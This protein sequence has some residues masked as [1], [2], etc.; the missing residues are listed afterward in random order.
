MGTQQVGVIGMAVM[1]KN[2]ALNIADHGYSVSIYNRTPEKTREI[3]REGQSEQIKASYS[4]EEF[5]HSLEKPRRIILMV[6]AGAAVDQTISQ[7]VPLLDR[8]DLIVD[9]GN[10]FY[11]DTMRRDQEL[12]DRGFRFMGAGISGGEEGARTG[13]AIMPGGEEDAY[14]LI[15]PVFSDI[16]A[17]VQGIPCSIHIGGDGAGHF[18]KMVHN[19]IEYGDMQLIS[20]AYWLLKNVLNLPVPRLREIFQVWNEGE[21]DSYLIEITAAI[22]AKADSETENYLVDMIL[23]I[24]HQKG[25][26]IWT[27]Q[28]ALELGV[29]IPTITEAVFQ[30]FLSGLKEERVLASKLGIE[31]NP[32]PKGLDFIEAVRRALYASKICT[33][34]QGF[35]LLQSASRRYDWK[36]NLGETAMIFRGGCII[37]AR[38]LNMVMDAFKHKPDLPNLL[39]DRV[40]SGILAAYQ[41]E[42][43]DVVATAAGCGIPVPGLSSALAYYDSYLSAQLPMNLVQAQRDFFG[44]HTY[45]RIDGEGNFH[46]RWQDN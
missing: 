1:G 13:P 19:G 15:G 29:P 42:W 10:S 30:R 8:G 9:G 31:L 40:F 37:R 3:E 11:R 46:T 6:K 23:D 5:V 26:G 39:L 45:R 18:V 32:I 41:E 38:L 16:A 35:A 17:K 28:A 43:R 2:L 22:F 7:L 27:S 34:A 33:Y 20:E 21:L 44:A 36:I 25:T 4:L 24:A 12:R 14:A